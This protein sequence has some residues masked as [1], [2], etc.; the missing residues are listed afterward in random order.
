MHH[1]CARSSSS[2]GRSPRSI[3]PRAS[4]TSDSGPLADAVEAAQRSACKELDF[5]DLDLDRYGYGVLDL[6][7][8]AATVEF[9]YVDTKDPNGTPYT[10]AR[11]R[12]LNGSQT[13]EQLP[14]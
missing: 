6:T 7:P 9:R 5:L 12:V 2:A 3:S 11:F 4:T 8:E 1:R 13:L 14:V 10:G